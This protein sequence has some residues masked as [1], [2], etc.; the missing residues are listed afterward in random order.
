[1]HIVIDLQ[2]AQCESRCRGIGRYSLSLARA[3]ARNRGGHRVTIALNSVF[4]A[5]IDPLKAAFEDILPADAIRVW[6][7]LEGV[8]GRDPANGWRRQAAECV[9]EAFLAELK[10]DVVL[11]SSLFEGFADDA[12]TS[13]PS[14]SEGYAT[15]VILYDLIPLIFR[16]AY[17]TNGLVSGWYNRKLEHLCRAD[18]LLSISA[19]SA[20]EAVQ[21]LGF[22]GNR[23][24]DISGA[25]D[26]K[27]RRIEMAD[28]E[29]DRLRS[30]AA[31]MLHPRTPPPFASANLPELLQP[32]RHSLLSAPPDL[33]V[34][35]RAS[36][37]SL[38][39]V[40]P[41]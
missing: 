24:T 39:P 27:F 14:V 10:P 34:L 7:G 29:A 28:D 22:P 8:H 30:V 37:V 38:P 23:I 13:V 20:S 3:I 16:D 5:S 35:P 26:P 11:V 25:A 31:R 18:F 2:G 33:V 1:M 41:V 36:A 15:A 40:P 4:A 21:H 17:L 19:S 9:C 32:L 6:Q 12:V